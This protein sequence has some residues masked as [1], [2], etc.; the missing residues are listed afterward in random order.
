MNKGGS[1]IIFAIAIFLLVISVIL[2]GANLSDKSLTLGEESS[3]EFKLQDSLSKNFTF[4]YPEEVDQSF[5]ITALIEAEGVISNMETNGLSTSYVRDT[6][7]VAKRSLIGHDYNL[8]FDSIELADSSRDKEYLESIKILTEE[9]PIFEIEKLDYANA[10]R[11]S[12]MIKF[13]KD[14]A[15]SIED[16]I[17]NMD[18]ERDELFE[19]VDVTSV[20][21]AILKVRDAFE[22]ERYSESVS[23]II[24]AETALDE[25]RAEERR[26]KGLVNLSK[27][28]V[29]RNWLKILLL[30]II[31]ALI[32][33]PIIKIV[34]IRIAK[35]KMSIMKLELDTLQRL[36]KKAQIECFKES[37]IS[38]DTYKIRERRYMARLNEIKHKLPVLESIVTGK[39]IVVRK[40]VKP[41]AILEF[42]K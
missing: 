29:E 40:D 5:A 35:K 12:E 8:F 16:Y 11:L 15:Y 2:F 36:L 24:E 26:V 34:R 6:L 10:I 31:I 41:K 33:K 23:L 18:L 25:A 14:K 7:L 4:I 13:T 20:D 39:E 19:S 3:G 17:T 22:N 42:K 1:Y 28:F 21:N 32:Y 38:E 27:S 9:T 30:I 37:K